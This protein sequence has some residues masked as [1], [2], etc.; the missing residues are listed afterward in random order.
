MGDE[1]YEKNSIE[2]I[3][4]EDSVH[5]EHEMEHFVSKWINRDLGLFNNLSNRFFLMPDY[6]PTESRIF[7]LSSHVIGD[8]VSLWSVFAHYT[9][10]YSILP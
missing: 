8:G 2:T 3:V 7:L 6:S 10:D 1:E 9:G 4:L 5:S